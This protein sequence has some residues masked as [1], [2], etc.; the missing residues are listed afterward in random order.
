MSR[1]GG[2]GEFCRQKKGGDHKGGEGKRIEAVV[3]WGRG[4]S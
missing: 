3:D 2:K 1:K 4:E